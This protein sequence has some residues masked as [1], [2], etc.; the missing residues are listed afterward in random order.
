M[1]F[2]R[3]SSQPRD[4]TDVSYCLLHWQEPPGKTSEHLLSEFLG[5]SGGRWGWDISE[6]ELVKRE[7]LEGLPGRERRASLSESF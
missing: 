2:S 3:E 1:P 5:E 7:D 6:L 4:R